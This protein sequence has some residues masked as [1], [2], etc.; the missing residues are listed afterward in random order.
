MFDVF[1]GVDVIVGIWGEIVGYFEKVYEFIYGL[2]VIQLY[3]FSYLECL[4]I[5]VLKIDYVVIFEEKYQ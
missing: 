4:G 1:I 3:V 2:D 5:Q